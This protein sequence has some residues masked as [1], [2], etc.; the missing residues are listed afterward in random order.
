[1]YDALR[2]KYANCRSFHNNDRLGYVINPR[3]ACAGGLQYLSCVF[4][5]V[6]T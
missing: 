4:L 5:S 3:R 1:M 6:T 2:S